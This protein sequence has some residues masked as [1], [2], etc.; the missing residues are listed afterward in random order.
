MESGGWSFDTLKFLENLAA[1]LK[2]VNK[3]ILFLFTGSASYIA[4]HILPT[5]CF[6]NKITAA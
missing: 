5:T 1:A 2:A 3:C 6:Y 4:G